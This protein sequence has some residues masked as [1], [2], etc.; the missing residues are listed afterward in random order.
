M[1]STNSFTTA[2]LEGGGGIIEFGLK[3]M[4]MEKFIRPTR[5]EALRSFSVQLW[6]ISTKSF[7][8]LPSA[9]VPVYV[10]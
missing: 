6:T 1:Q 7:K 4:K 10:K 5:T 9:T 8:T 2:R 3:F